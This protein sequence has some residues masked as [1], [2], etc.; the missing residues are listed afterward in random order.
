[1]AWFTHEHTFF[2][3]GIDHETAGDHCFTAP[4]A[5]QLRLGETG[6]QG[7]GGADPP[8]ELELRTASQGLICQP[9]P[10]GRKVQNNT[11]WCIGRPATASLPRPKEL[12]LVPARGDHRLGQLP[13]LD[14]AERQGGTAEGVLREV[15][16]GLHQ[17]HRGAGCTQLLCQARAG[18]TGARN[19]HIPGSL[20]ARR[21]R[22]PQPGASRCRSDPGWTRSSGPGSGPGPPCFGPVWRGPPAHPGYQSGAPAPARPCR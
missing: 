7:L 14:G 1:M 17:Q 20:I 9:A 22:H 2:S 19:Q 3:G 10:Q 6:A 16:Q 12:P 11:E 4:R 13:T 21:F 18:R 8:A 15:L 5:P